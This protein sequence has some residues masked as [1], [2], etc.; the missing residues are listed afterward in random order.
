MSGGAG[1]LEEEQEQE[2]EEEESGSSSNS[3]SSGSDEAAMED[4]PP[5][6]CSTVHAALQQGP[7]THADLEASYK[8][9]LEMAAMLGSVGARE[10]QKAWL[11]LHR[12]MEQRIKATPGEPTD[13]SSL[14]QHMKRK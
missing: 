14:V 3:S 12:A 1:E 11:I 9:A 2:E 10:Q 13:L 4:E 6:P 5:P 8:L 7:A